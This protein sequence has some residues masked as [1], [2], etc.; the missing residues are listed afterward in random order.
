MADVV[1]PGREIANGVTFEYTN[2][3]ETTQS[4]NDCISR[5]QTRTIEDVQEARTPLDH[6]TTGSSSV[7]SIH[8]EPPPVVV[9]PPKVEYRGFSSTALSWFAWVRNE[10][11][12]I[13]NCARSIS[14]SYSHQAKFQLFGLRLSKDVT[15]RTSENGVDAAII[16]IRL[17]GLFGTRHPRQTY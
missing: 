6:R 12:D 8:L 5:K 10:Q 17:V 15:Y 3:S 7:L 9:K 2:G 11:A 14:L 13:P 1:S 16:H 4:P